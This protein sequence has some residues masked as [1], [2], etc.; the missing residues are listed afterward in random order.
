MNRTELAVLGAATL[1]V[2]IA[3]LWL[4]WQASTMIGSYPSCFYHGDPRVAPS[5]DG[6]CGALLVMFTEQMGWERTLKLG[7]AATAAP[8]VLG[9]LLGAPIVARELEHRTA[10]MA[11]SL[12]RARTVWLV[13]RL[14]PVASFLIVALILIGIAGSWFEDARFNT[15]FWRGYSPW[16]LLVARGLLTFAIGVLCGALVGRVLPAVLLT[17]LACAIFLPIGTLMDRWMRA[18]A[19]PIVQSD[20]AQTV[21]ARTFAT[22][23][24]DDATGELITMNDYYNAPQGIAVAHSDTPVGMTLVDLGIPATRYMEFVL[25]ESAL[26]VGLARVVGGLALWIVRRRRPY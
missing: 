7:L 26:T 5:E 10:G 22:L 3:L 6:Q 16:P 13:Q 11:W 12:A 20:V 9:I 21:G 4:G 1:F 14:L 2:S 8:F 17:A 23:F 24:R 19:V 18:E 25:R 15:G